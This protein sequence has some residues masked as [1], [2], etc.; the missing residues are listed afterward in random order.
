MPIPKAEGETYIKEYIRLQ[1]KLLQLEDF[2]QSS[3]ANM[4]SYHSS[5]LIS[6]IFTKERIDAL[7]QYQN[8]AN[9]LRIYYG[10]HSNGDPTLV[11][12]P[13][14]VSEDETSVINKLAGA[15][16]ED[17]VEQHPKPKTGTGGSGFMGFDLENDPI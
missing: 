17:R 2:L 9:A 14:Q 10:A 4:K 6:F 11:L 13:C 16:A 3:D 5:G 12:V 7:F 8:D 1:N 15:A